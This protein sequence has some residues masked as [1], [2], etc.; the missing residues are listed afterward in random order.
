M[1]SILFLSAL[2]I[3]VSCGGAKNKVIVMASGDVTAAENTITLEE[4][5][6]HNELEVFP[7]SPTLVVKEGTNSRNVELN[8][9]GLFLLNLKKDTLV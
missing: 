6:S 3:L 2:V 8:G 9:N 4:G 1:R 5:S 7:T